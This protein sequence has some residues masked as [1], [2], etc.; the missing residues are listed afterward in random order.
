MDFKK[1]KHKIEEK[2]KFHE[3]D[4]MGVVNNAIYFSY[5]EDARMAYLKYLKDNYDLGEM[6]EEDS[7]FIMAHNEINYLLPAKYD[8]EL[9][10]YTKIEWIKITSIGF[11]HVVVNK[12]S[13][14]T[15]AIGHGVMVHIKLSTKKKQN[16]P[17]SFISAIEDFEK[18]VIKMKN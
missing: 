17:T 16:L 14:K 5:F 9:I 8:E 2:V 12:I 13:N 7:F 15:I 3:V 4:M 1:Y 6:M 11:N 10:V 18:G